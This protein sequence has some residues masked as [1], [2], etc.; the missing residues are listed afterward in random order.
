MQHRVCPLLTRLMRRAESNHDEERAVSL[1]W[2]V[3]GFQEVSLAHS[4]NP[5]HTVNR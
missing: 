4:T 3:C 1:L 5:A 2:V